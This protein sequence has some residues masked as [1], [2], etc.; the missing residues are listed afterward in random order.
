[1]QQRNTTT[2]NYRE[3]RSCVC[4]TEFGGYGGLVLRC[5]VP[6]VLELLGCADPKWFV[7]HLP[8]A[9]QTMLD[10]FASS[11]SQCDVQ[12]KL[13]LYNAVHTN[14][15]GSEDE[16]SHL[17]VLLLG[18]FSLGLFVILSAILNKY[19]SFNDPFS[20]TWTYWYIREAST[21][22][23]VANIPTCWPLARRVF[24]LTS[25]SSSDETKSRTRTK[26]RSKSYVSA[27]RME[28][29]NSSRFPS[30]KED[31]IHKTESMQNIVERSMD[32]KSDEA[33]RNMGE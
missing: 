2:R 1:M 18:L 22:I 11:D 27:M 6:T 33:T 21:A 5:L 7:I 24:G 30:R 14:A 31:K 16:A 12:H 3:N 28:G 10:C 17:Q 29:T 25:W 26:P 23:Y 4:R 15:F 13:R 8:I 20:V 19:E 9:M 32:G